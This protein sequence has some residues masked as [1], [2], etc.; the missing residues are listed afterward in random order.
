MNSSLASLRNLSSNLLISPRRNGPSFRSSVLFPILSRIAAMASEDAMASP[1]GFL[2][3]TMI[4]PD[5]FL[6][7]SRS[8]ESHCGNILAI[9]CYHPRLGAVDHV[10]LIDDDLPDS[11]DRG[12]V[13]ADAEHEVLYYRPQASGAGLLLEGLVR[14][15]I[16]RIIG[17]AEIYAIE[18]E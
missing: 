9:V 3:A 10:V 6:I 15:R 2:W 11:L 8:L 5:A 4:A 17:E 12:D 7:A 14:Y 1:S 18:G 16:D 13:I